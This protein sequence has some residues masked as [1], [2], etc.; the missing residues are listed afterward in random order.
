MTVYLDTGATT[1]IEP[2]VLDVMVHFLKDDY[3]NAA[4]RTHDYG[5]RAK[6]AVE[7]ARRTIAG[8]VSSESNE[9][10]FT[11]GATESNN[12]AIL[13]L[14]TYGEQSGKRH[15]ITTAI[16]HKA[17]LEPVD[18]LKSLGFDVTII[19]STP[20]GYVNASDVANNLRDDTLLVSVMH[21]NNETG[22]I[23]PISDIVTCL[24]GHEAYFHVDAA[25]GFG[26]D[27]SPLTNRRIDL[28]S[29]SAH[30]IFGPKGVGCLVA[31]RRSSS[32]PPLQPLMFGGGHE[33]GLRPGTLPVPHIVGF[34]AAARVAI[35]DLKKRRAKCERVRE[36]FLDFIGEIGG[37]INGDPSRSVPH[38][39][40]ISIPG[41]DAEAAIVALKQVIAVSNG[42][43]CTSSSY[44]PS[45]VLTA[46]ALPDDRVH[47]AIRFSWCHLT[48][49]ID[50]ADVTNSIRPFL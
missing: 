3:G 12:L 4:S 11:S 19:P 9:L 44:E 42:S 6:K 48:D 18:H 37:L 40:N 5:R 41:L 21:V 17:V 23:Q 45:H 2:E 36:R 30:K 50:W 25:Q 27:P 24:E 28:I 32:R 16:E 31:R 46:M 1:P 49:E 47:S 8:S 10:I 26:K 13:G 38:I 7:D 35:R 20:G 34:G 33:F 14:R 43:A 39:A 22:T 15:I 29:V